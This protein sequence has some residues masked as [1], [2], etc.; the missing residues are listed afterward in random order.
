MNGWWMRLAMVLV[1]A[2]PLA[3]PGSGCGGDDDDDDDDTVDDDTVDDD[4]VDDDTTDDDTVDDDTADDDT[5]DDDTGD[6]DTV[7]PATAEIEPLAWA[8]YPCPAEGVDGGATVRVGNYNLYGGN[9]ATKEEI[10][11]GVVDAAPDLDLLMLQET[12]DAAWAQAIADAL[13][14]DYVYFSGGKAIVSKTALSNTSEI[15][16]AAGRSVLHANTTIDGA[17]F[18]VYSV[19]IGWNQPGDDQCR[20]FIDETIADDPSSRI[21]AAGDWNEELGSTQVAI[22]NERLHEGWAA[23]GEVTSHR[24]SWP[25]TGFYGSEGRQL[26]DN[27]YV[28]KTSGACA[29]DGEIVNFHPVLADHKLEWIRWVFPDIP[30]PTPPRVLDVLDGLGDNAFGLLFDRPMASA[31]VE[32]ASADGP[33]AVD[34]VD[35]VGDGSI[36]RVTLTDAPARPVE[37]TATVTAAA[38]VDG[39]GTDGEIEHVFTLVPNL[40][41][42]PGAEEAG[43]ASAAG[44][45]A[46]DGMRATD[47]ADMGALVAP[48]TPFAGDYFYS[49]VPG[50]KRGWA[51]QTVSLA[52]NIDAIDDGRAYLLF[53][54]A[55]T[56]GY[57][58]EDGD[59]SNALR[60]HDECEGTAEV[61]DADGAV[62]DTLS[63]DRFDTM[64]WQPWRVRAPLPPGARSVRVTLRA[65]AVEIPQVFNTA[66]F[67][68]ISLGVWEDDAP[69]G[70][71]GGNLL[72]N[73]SFEDD[74]SGW[75]GSDE[76]STI[77]DHN[78]QLPLIYDATN[79]TAKGE[80]S[81]KAKLDAGVSAWIEQSVDVSAWPTMIDA[82]ELAVRWGGAMRNWAG[83][84]PMSLSVRFMETDIV[85]DEA[86]LPVNRDPEWFT[87]EATTLVPAGTRSI[88]MR[89]QADGVEGDPSAFFDGA[90][91]DP[92]AVADF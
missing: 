61:L 54:G 78:L 70:R 25:A 89:F 7:E 43:L 41:G 52:D 72:V 6:D 29:V 62:I 81:L 46:L 76:M 48:V 22:L 59:T 57:R 11:A 80:Y 44:T 40:I 77:R 79:N 86:S 18:S 83:T 75:V 58:V 19:H 34:G 10:A 1:V 4:T 38:D 66:S 30:A 42:D 60:A 12:P 2:V 36:V 85:I 56:A 69:H 68:A 28:N 65:V 32:V 16:F 82:G 35:T 45:F 74:L 55:C 64:Y 27:S 49:G 33:V 87:H 24:T 90:F 13:G 5:A 88:V 84:S 91:L 73:A 50:E 47:G 63:S 14:A 26:I 31:S 71:L 3:L 51:R 21:I 15:S 37:L 8:R 9:Y 17:A 67:D 53:G 39:V 20:E 23:L 92:V